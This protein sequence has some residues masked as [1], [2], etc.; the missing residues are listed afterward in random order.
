MTDI[1]ISKMKK[2]YVLQKLFNSSRAQGMGFLQ[3]HEEPMTSDEAKDLLDDG[4]NYFDYLRGRVM[5]IDLSG[6]V[7][8]TDLYDRDNGQGAA[9][10]A[11][12]VDNLDKG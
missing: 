10:S 11:L 7:L 1:D 5:K 3:N 8:R 2:E 9:A 6:D 4:Q 12:G